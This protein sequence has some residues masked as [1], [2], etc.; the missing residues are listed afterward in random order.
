MDHL[1]SIRVVTSPQILKIV[2]E[3]VVPAVKGDTTARVI[4]NIRITKVHPVHNIGVRT[5]TIPD[6]VIMDLPIRFFLLREKE[7]STSHS[8]RN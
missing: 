2:T 1:R 3:V 4:T 6:P 5:H 7:I 8:L